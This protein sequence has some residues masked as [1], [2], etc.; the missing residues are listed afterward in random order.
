MTK[1]R[2]VAKAQ[3][4][5]RRNKE[6]AWKKLQPTIVTPLMEDAEHNLTANQLRL[7]AVKRAKEARDGNNT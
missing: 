7:R 3:K 6:R 1:K 2:V 5:R 4:I